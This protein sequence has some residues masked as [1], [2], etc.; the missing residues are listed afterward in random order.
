MESLVDWPFPSIHDSKEP[1][2][3]TQLF[4]TPKECSLG[5]QQIHASLR[6]T[7]E[8]DNT[9]MSS[10]ADWKN[11]SV[12][13]QGDFRQHTFSAGSGMGRHLPHMHHPGG[14]DCRDSSS[15]GSPSL[16][17]FSN[18]NPPLL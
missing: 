2:D 16:T 10:T 9:F 18:S 14:F 15:G 5:H 8:I 3:D 11:S 17:D 4:N 13:T 7:M 1:T 12:V 6:F